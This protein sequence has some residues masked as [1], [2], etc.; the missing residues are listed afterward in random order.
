MNSPS[1][2]LAERIAKR[3][4]EASLLTPEAAKRLTPKLAEGKLTSE[5]WRLPIEL[6]TKK[7]EKK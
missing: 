7:E 4:V 6:G 2:T 3:L 1:Q 5:D